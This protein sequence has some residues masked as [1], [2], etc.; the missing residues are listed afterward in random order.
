MNNPEPGRTGL[1]GKTSLESATGALLSDAFPLPGEE[2]DSAAACG[3]VLARSIES[4]RP[5]PAFNRSAMDGFAVMSTDIKQAPVNLAIIGTSLPGAP[6][7]RPVSRGMAIRITTGAAIP[8]G[9]DTVVPIEL[10]D[11]SESSVVVRS[12]LPAGKHVIVSGEDFQ[13]GQTVLQAGHRLR[14]HD[15]AVL[16]AMGVARV[17]VVRRPFVSILVT[18]NELF[19]P[20]STPKNDLIS[21]ANS[22]MLQALSGRDGAFSKTC[23]SVPDT[24]RDVV[25][26]LRECAQSDVILISGGSSVGQEDHVPAAVGK[27]GSLEVHGLA[28][29][30]A[31]PAGFG[32]LACGTRVFLLPGNPVSCLCAYELLAGKFIRRLAGLSSDFPHTMLR[33]PLA[34]DLVSEIGRTDFARVRI[35]HGLV[36]PVAISGAGRLSTVVQADGFVLIP[37]EIGSF[38]KGDE[39][40]VRLF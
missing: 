20:F 39:V 6:A 7:G 32:R 37:P 9:A 28:L 31:S 34:R 36:E 40:V 16:S 5:I 17:N 15:L 23:P 2:T 35:S 4:P 33:L 26:A 14:P 8:A 11:A 29:R 3:R 10:C 19:P 12:P 1:R 13:A 21:D 22:P 30:P 25:S 27:L 38:N 24:E 18:G